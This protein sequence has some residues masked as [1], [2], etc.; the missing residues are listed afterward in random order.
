MLKYA[1]TYLGTAV[2]F[3]AVDLVWILNANAVIYR[4]TLNP[5]LADTVRL[6]PAVAFYLIYILGLVVLGVARAASWRQAAA[7][8]AMLGLFAYA[9]YD[10][11]NQ[12][13]LK[14]WS[15]TITLADISWGTAV[16]AWGAVAGYLVLRWARQRFG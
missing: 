1:L 3:A 14:V 15:T 7:N 11:T 16:S 9:T 6:A 2:A 12:A 4:P 10:L 13:T 5:V 8:G